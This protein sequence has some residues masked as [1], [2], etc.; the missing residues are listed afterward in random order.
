MAG[1]DLP[2]TVHKNNREDVTD[3]FQKFEIERKAQRSSA[4]NVHVSRVSLVRNDAS[5]L[6]CVKKCAALTSGDEIKST[7]SDT[8]STD[9]LASDSEPPEQNQMERLD[10]IA[11]EMDRQNLLGVHMQEV[12]VVINL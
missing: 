3:K 10:E 7:V 8:W 1:P 6:M 11:E 9:V 4:C 2:V 12:V 5:T